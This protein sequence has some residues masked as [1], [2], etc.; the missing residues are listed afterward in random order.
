MEKYRITII[1]EGMSSLSKDV[2]ESKLVASLFDI[3]KEEKV[4][5]GQSNELEILDYEL[6]EAIPI[7]S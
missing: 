6:T 1:A 2:L 3:D 7:S 5:D 4:A